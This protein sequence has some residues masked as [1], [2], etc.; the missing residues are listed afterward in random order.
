M[1]A[2]HRGGAMCDLSPQRHRPHRTHHR[3][4]RRHSHSPL[5]VFIKS[6]EP[7]TTFPGRRDVG[8]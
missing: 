7:Q 5:S 4:R 8:T 6:Q 1:V 2:R 3:R